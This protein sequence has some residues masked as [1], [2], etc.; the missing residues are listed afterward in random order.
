MKIHHIFADFQFSFTK[1]SP[2]QILQNLSFA[3]FEFP[4]CRIFAIRQLNIRKINPLQEESK[5]VHP[6]SFGAAR[7]IQK[8]SD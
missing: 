4:Q 8:W 7:R 5:N 3:K 2:R 6:K 1:L